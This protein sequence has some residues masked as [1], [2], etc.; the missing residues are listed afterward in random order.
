MALTARASAVACLLLAL[1]ASAAGA[2]S[3]SPAPAP[4]VDCFAAA[5]SLLDCM[6]YVSPRS[7]E[8]T[9]SKACCGE[10]KTAV[11]NPTTVNCL[12]TLA[13]SKDLPVAIDMK[14]VLALPGA[15]GASNAAFSKCH[16]SAGSPTEVCRVSRF[17][18]AFVLHDD[19]SHEKLLSI[20]PTCAICY[21]R[22]IERRGDRDTTTAPG[23]GE[24]SDDG[25]R[26]RGRRGGPAARLL[27][28]L[29]SWG[30]LRSDA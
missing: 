18:T 27:L 9:P 11:A 23:G 20:P 5:S 4:A 25:D 1:A 16:I 8:K 26:P 6:G 19:P 17:Q 10:V 2:G 21:R 7:T 28:P 15:C 24:L 30:Y 22:I 14:R 29:L 3:H 12:C 13:G